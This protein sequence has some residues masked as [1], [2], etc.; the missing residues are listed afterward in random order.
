V[1][2]RLTERLL[3]LG[4]V[5]ST[6]RNFFSGRAKS[7]P[8][9]PTTLLF[10]E[11]AADAVVQALAAAEVPGLQLAPEPL[12]RWP[13]RTAALAAGDLDGD[14]ASELVV[15]TEEAVEVRALDG[16][17]LARR[18]LDALPM[19]ALPSREP[20]G[21]LCVCH[22]LLYAFSA[23][24][25]A[26]EVLALEARGLVVRETLRRPVVACGPPLLEATFLP[27]AARLAPA[28]DGWPP[29]PPGAATWGILGKTWASG[30][31]VLLLREDGTATAVRDTGPPLTV[32]GVGAGAALVEGAPEGALG[33]LAASSS[34]PAPAEDNLRLLALKDGTPQGG[35]QLKG[36]ILQVATGRLSVDGA[37]ALVLGVWREDG[38]A[39][40]R[41][42]R[43]L[44]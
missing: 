41:L 5:S 29:L 23:T 36:R 18:A 26:G 2:L 33:L 32:R 38:G 17:L 7:M 14:G 35:L 21:T 40:L 16:H 25:A 30:R 6:W 24:R 28:G 43:G 1:R 3:A 34:A 37:E 9:R 8:A 42:V 22:G 11:V 20:F 19:A 31:V 27:G 12:A 4:D 44:P 15:L 13:V 10:A 39:E